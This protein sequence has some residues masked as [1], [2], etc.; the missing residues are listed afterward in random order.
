[1]EGG[2]RFQRRKEDFVC[3]WCGARVKGT[4]YTDHC[5]NCPCGKHVDNN[6]GDRAS[7]CR[8]KMVPLSA[9]YKS[10][11]FMITYRCVVCGKRKRVRAAEGDNRELLVTLSTAQAKRP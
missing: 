4:G 10:M 11:E 3:E 7:D 9:E 5:P 8:G 2:K 6:P 1:M